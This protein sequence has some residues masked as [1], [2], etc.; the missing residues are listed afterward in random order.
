MGWAGKRQTN[1]SL[2][3][4]VRQYTVRRTKEERKDSC[5]QKSA[6]GPCEQQVHTDNITELIRVHVHNSPRKIFNFSALTARQK[7]AFSENQGFSLL[8]TSPAIKRPPRSL[9]PVF[10]SRTSREQRIYCI[11]KPN[12]SFPARP[13]QSSL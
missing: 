5:H 11:F 10:R 1:P 6:A 3:V 4:R 2:L 8:T 13:Q 7:D 12:S 9:L